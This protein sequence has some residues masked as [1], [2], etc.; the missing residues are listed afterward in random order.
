MKVSEKMKDILLN[1]IKKLASEPKDFLVNPERDFTRKRKFD[2]V[3]LLKFIICMEA[4]SIKDEL[5][6]Y[7]GL[8]IDNPTASA[9]VEQRQ[10][11]K[12]EAFEWLFKEFNEATRDDGSK[13][14]FHGYRLIAIDGSSL[15]ISYDPLDEETYIKQI[16]KFQEISKGYNAF[17]LTASYDLLEHTYDDLIIQGE[18]YM[19]E[20]GAFNELVDRYNGEPTI[21][22]ADRGFESY[23]S[24]THVIKSNNKFLIRIRDIHSKNSIAKGLNL[25]LDGEFD[26]DIKRILTFKNTNEIKAHPEIYRF[27][28][29][30]SKFDYM[31]K[32][33]PF[34]E[35]ECRIV[36]FKITEDT[37][38]VIATNLNRNEFNSKIIKELYS[39]RW[40]IETSFRELKYAIGMNAFHAKNRNSIKQEIYARILLYNLSERI[41][42]KVKPKKVKNRKK[43][44][45]YQINFTRA[46]HNTMT[47]LKIKDGESP[48]DIE[49]IIAK[50]IEPIRPGRSD[51]RKIRR[52]DMVFFTYRF[53]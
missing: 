27:M 33:N 43:K 39:M 45:L 53:I 3:T 18:A 52:P 36:R 41:I 21:F 6:R 19:N 26:V 20:N 48:P 25:G 11:L 8:N 14:K 37:Y 31:N 1:K 22:I 32:E 35:F 16:N 42:R 29:T 47:Y 44:Y 10:K 46:F 51:P 12:P 7:F 9:F 17:H 2:L 23:N 50:E 15:P 5:Y 24:F 49:A 30:T 13:M 40:G 4:G 28:S 38:E 34:Y